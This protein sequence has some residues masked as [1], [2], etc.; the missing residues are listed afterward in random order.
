[1]LGLLGSGVQ[2]ISYA[3]AVY[4]GS[5]IMRGVI[6]GNTLV[7]RLD[8][9]DSNISQVLERL[10]SHSARTELAE[11]HKNVKPFQERQLLELDDLNQNIATATGL[12]VV[13]SASLEVLTEFDTL[14]AQLHGM[15]TH[16]DLDSVDISRFLSEASNRANSIPIFVIGRREICTGS[17]SID[18]FR[19]IGL[20]YIPLVRDAILGQIDSDLVNSLGREIY[21]SGRHRLPNFDSSRAVLGCRPEPGSVFS[22]R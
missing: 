14:Q 8:R 18:G 15:C 10:N 16:T 13:S 17:L 3:V 7:S 12:S 2:A 21:N 4:Q 11:F 5:Q 9:L 6:T 22:M 20:I 1:M 19:S